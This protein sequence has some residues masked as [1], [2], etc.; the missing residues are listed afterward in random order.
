MHG[1][2]FDLTFQIYSQHELRRELDWSQLLKLFK[3][4]Q[5][6]A[7]DEKTELCVYLRNFHKNDMKK[8][9]KFQLNHL[10]PQKASFSCRGGSENA[11]I[12]N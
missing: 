9:E 4:D 7:S 5:R 11:L 6:T 2:G 1:R 3:L 12:I 8:E 10:S